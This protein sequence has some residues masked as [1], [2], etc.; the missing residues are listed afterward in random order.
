M[1]IHI[2]YDLSELESLKPVFSNIQKLNGKIK[3]KAGDKNERLHL[4]FVK[5]N[6]DGASKN[7]AL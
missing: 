3:I 5:K 7:K 2:R 4:Y 1:K 6:N